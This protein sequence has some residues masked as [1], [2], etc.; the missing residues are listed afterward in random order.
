MFL[1]SSSLDIDLGVYLKDLTIQLGSDGTTTHSDMS[2]STQLNGHAC[3]W[4]YTW[5]L[6]FGTANRSKVSMC[7]AR[8]AR[9]VLEKSLIWRRIATIPL[10]ADH[11]QSH[12]AAT[13]SMNELHIRQS[14]YDNWQSCT[15]SFL[16]DFQPQARSHPPPISDAGPI[17]P[18]WRFDRFESK[19]VDIVHCI[20]RPSQAPIHNR[21]NCLH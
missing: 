11:A 7:L 4:I 6:E 14:H 12:M 16:L 18:D 20:C 10:S 9:Q 5:R 8:H 3:A 19:P 21:L 17:D 2:R 1:T 15:H 13:L